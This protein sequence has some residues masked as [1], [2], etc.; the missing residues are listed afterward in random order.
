MSAGR[1]YVITSLEEDFT[2]LGLLAEAKDDS[3]SESAEVSSE[4][5]EEEVTEA[6]EGSKEDSVAEGS[7]KKR[8]RVSAKERMQN[9]KRA[10]SAKAKMAKKRY[11]K[12][13]KGKKQ[14]AKH[15][16]LLK[17]KGGPRKGYVFKTDD[18]DTF[19]GL[20]EELKAVSDRIAEEG[21]GVT[22]EEAKE[23]FANVALAANALV[24]AFSKISE[25]VGDEDFKGISE[26]F[27]E[28]AETAAAMAQKIEAG[29]LEES[30]EETLADNLGESISDLLDGIELYVGCLSE[31]E[32]SSEDK[33]SDEGND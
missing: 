31:E 24:E 27:Q 15:A 12:S 28:L 16:R 9:K 18:V 29:E 3:D 2:D 6:G 20:L 26:A 17:Q 7:F 11:A 14:A 10:K 30:D 21:E 1:R 8:K 5:S 32:E 4:G 33:S 13:A 22:A 19:N 23:T 25:D